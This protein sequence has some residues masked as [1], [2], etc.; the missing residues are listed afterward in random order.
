MIV[1]M[2]CPP[3]GAE[4]INS[5]AL[6][7]YLPGALGAFLDRLRAELVSTCQARSHVTVLPPRQLIASETLAK[8]QIAER[9]PEYP[10]FRVD[11]GEVE[12]FPETKVIY[13]GVDRGGDRLSAMHDELNASSLIFDEPFVY[14]P[15]VTLAQQIDP[16]HVEDAVDL[17]AA[18]W[19]EFRHSRSFRVETLTFVQNTT[20]NCWLDL[21][22]Y[23]LGTMAGVRR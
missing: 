10:P 12:V 5:F 7:C 23:E 8:R 1:D 20:S 22:E 18:R 3:S 2:D 13:L 4:R 9:V 14:H 11:L 16:F 21:A 15:H 6:V 17:A 19:R